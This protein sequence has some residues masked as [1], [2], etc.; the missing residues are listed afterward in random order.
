MN[1][2]NDT[3]KKKLMDQFI[4][5][6]GEDAVLGEEEQ[7]EEFKDPYGPNDSDKYQPL[8]VVQPSTVEEV[9]DIVKLANELDIHLWSSGQGRNFGYGGSSPV[10]SGS[11]IVNFRRMNKILEINEE[12]GYALV[13]PGVSFDQLYKEIQS[14]GYKLMMSVPDLGWGSIVGNSSQHGYGYTI[15]GEHA[16]AINGMEVVLAN[17]EVLRTGQGAKADSKMWQRHDRGFGPHLDDLFKQSNFGIITKMGVRLE[18]QPEKITAGYIYY[19]GKDIEK[20]VDVIKPLVMDKTIQGVPL[21]YSNLIIGEVGDNRKDLFQKAED[22]GMRMPARWVFRIQFYGQENMVNARVE[23]VKKAFENLPEVK[24]EVETYVGNVKKEDVKPEHL[25]PAG[26]PNMLMLEQV[27]NSFGDS[28]GHI[29]FAP[30]IPF[31][32]KE[33]LEVE[34]VVQNVLE[35]YGLFGMTGTAMHTR[36]LVPITMIYFDTNDPN[37]VK[38]GYEAAKR[39]VKEVGELGYTEYRAHVSL[40]DDIA[41]ELDFNDHA[42]HKFYTKIKDALDPK[43]ILSPGSHGIW[44]S[45]FKDGEDQ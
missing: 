1:E 40:M 11:V 14:K 18:P 10:V 13:E 6:L 23:N 33:L 25:V 43:G 15:N 20:V 34:E 41:K 17:G 37:Q 9:Q 8:L 35:E 32:G 44:P 2:N 4:S 29:E 26:I 28:V 12:D 38:A 30:V 39:L 27:K 7:I 31:D 45:N 36:S 3:N 42:L 22:G 19:D 24:I 21:L 16:K 5:I